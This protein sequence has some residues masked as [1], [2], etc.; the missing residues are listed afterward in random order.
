[1]EK[2]PGGYF[3]VWESQKRTSININHY[4]LININ[5]PTTGILF[6]GVIE[7]DR[8]SWLKNLMVK[9]VWISQVTIFKAVYKFIWI[10]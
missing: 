5:H 4:S 2:D 7:L 9:V 3:N 6:N 8:E 1:M 10:L